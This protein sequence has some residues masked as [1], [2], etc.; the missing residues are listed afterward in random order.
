MEPLTMLSHLGPLS[1]MPAS[2]F[3]T[4]PCSPVKSSFFENHSTWLP[5]ICYKDSPISE[6]TAAS[7][8]TKRYCCDLYVGTIFST[9]IWHCCRCQMPA[10]PYVCPSHS[11]HQNDAGRTWNEQGSLEEVHWN[12]SPS[13]WYTSIKPKGWALKFLHW[14]SS[15]EEPDS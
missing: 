11:L 10:M 6:P 2:L 4:L 5:E 3:P 9:T 14:F 1:F 8:I 13:A 7:P 12:P 15:S